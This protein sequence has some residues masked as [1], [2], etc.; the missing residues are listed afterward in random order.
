M[1]L[2]LIQFIKML[3]NQLIT[4]KPTRLFILIIACM[5]VLHLMAQKS[6]NIGLAYKSK[7]MEDRWELG[8]QNHKGLFVITPYRPVYVTAGRWSNSPNTKPTSENPDYTLPFRINYN[9][10]EAKFQL[11][12]KTKIARS[13]F[14]GNGDIW[15]AYTQ[16]AHWQ[17]YNEK[18][19]RPF[20]E[21]NYEPEVFLNFATNYKLF[22]L[23]GRML[24]IIFN[25]QSNG[26]TL[27]LSR[28]WNRV[29]VQ[30]G[31]EKNNWQLML[32]VWHRLKD[33]VDENPAIADYIGRSEATIIFNAGKCQFSS[34][35]THSLKL[36]N[37]GRGS[38]QL[39][40]VFPV[41]NNLRGQIQLTEGYGETMMDYNHRQTTIGVSVS[42]VEW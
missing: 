8:R 26:K 6:D 3:Q 12:F 27:P 14:W 29:I 30:A 38:A 17:L 9:N 41:I 10:Y 16:K 31:F 35:L 36:K 21:L 42:L 28:S 18:L 24:G 7:T 37:G 32:R 15:V 23:K 40:W 1:H 19:S 34:V 33:D 39:N 22:G 2:Y 20:R 13:L 11:S 5:P 25:H 4:L